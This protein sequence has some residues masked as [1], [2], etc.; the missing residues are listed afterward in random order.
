M[1]R[2]AA[3]RTLPLPGVSMSRV[4]PQHLQGSVC[5]YTPIDIIERSRQVLGGFDLDPASDEFGNSRVKAH[6]YYSERGLER[7]WS[8]RVF[9]NPPGGRGSAKKWFQKFISEDCWGVFVAFNLELFQTC[10][11]SLSYPFCVPSKRLRY[12]KPDSKPMSPTHASAIIFKLMDWGP[13]RTYTEAFHEAFQGVG[14]V[15]THIDF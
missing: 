8:G 4:L 7:P 9:C 5:W 13:T 2:S 10:P 14:G 15:V 1:S 6:Q 12:E 11:E 3:E